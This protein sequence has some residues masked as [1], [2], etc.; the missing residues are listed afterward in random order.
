MDI[1][2]AKKDLELNKL[3][4]AQIGPLILWFIRGNDEIHIAVKRLEG[5]LAENDTVSFTAMDMDNKDNLDFER[6]V[7]GDNCH[8]ISIVPIMP[9]HPVVVRPE[10]P[11]KIPKDHEALFFV[12]IPVWIKIVAKQ[13]DVVLCQ[14]PSIILSNIWF[15]D[16]TSG[17]LCYSLRSRARRQ[18]VDAESKPHRAVCPVRIRNSTESM[19]NVERFC[20]H[21]EYLKIFKGAR[22]LWTN[23]AQIN[24]QGEDAASKINYMQKPP[25]YESVDNILSEA[26]SP[27]KKT[28]LK[29]SLGTFKL[30]TGI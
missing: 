15:G 7:V 21:V 9:D 12:S 26:R 3:F 27:L 8:Q 24:F 1:W 14:E 25:E 10:V 11:V 18:I 2:I 13:S 29:K 16:P 5:K 19:L 22:R 4:R 6:W 20:V 23:E 17:E 28:L 30:F